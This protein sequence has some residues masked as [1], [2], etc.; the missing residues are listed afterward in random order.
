MHNKTTESNFKLG[1]V[2]G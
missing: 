1:T 2:K